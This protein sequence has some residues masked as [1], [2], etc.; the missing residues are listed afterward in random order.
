M[1]MSIGFTG[2]RKGM[3]D[4]QKDAVRQ[5]IA[6]LL[7]GRCVVGNKAVHGCCVGADADFVKIAASMNYFN[8]EIVA[9]RSDIPS[10]IDPEAF[11][12]S[13]ILVAPKPPLVRNQN[14]VEESSVMIAC[15]ETAEEV[16]RSGTWATVRFARKRGKPLA[17]VN[18]D[19]SVTKERWVEG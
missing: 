16:V 2:T 10:M 3:T 7:E 4:A 5:L 13:D 14:I 15:P 6:D 9:H 8:L 1:S 12:L 18:P 19:G 17:I 11:S